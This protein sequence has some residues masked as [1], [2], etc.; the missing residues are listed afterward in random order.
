MLKYSRLVLR[1]FYSLGIEDEILLNTDS[2]YETNLIVDEETGASGII[3]SNQTRN[4][5]SIAGTLQS[6]ER[7]S[8]FTYSS[9]F[10]G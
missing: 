6:N 4:S 2:G 3:V 5:L 10:Q 8:S 9:S 7:V 1:P